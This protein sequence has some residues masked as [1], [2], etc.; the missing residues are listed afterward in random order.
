MTAHKPASMRASRGGRSE[1]QCQAV[2]A[3]ALASRRRAIVEYM[4]EM[5]AAA[6]TMHLRAGHE[7]GIVLLGAD[8][9]RQRFPEARPASAGIIFGFRGIGRQVA[10][11]TMEDTLAMFFEQGTGEG[12]LR[13]FL[14]QHRILLPGQDFAPLGF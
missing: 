11:G 5:A 9:I 12:A 13:G 8:R 7:Q 6:S 2:Q 1:G 10:T 3:M 14:A 4:A